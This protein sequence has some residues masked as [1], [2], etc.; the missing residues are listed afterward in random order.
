M[1]RE[2]GVFFIRRCSAQDGSARLPKCTDETTVGANV[3]AA[4]MGEVLRSTYSGVQ[5][6]SSERRWWNLPKRKPR[7]CL[8]SSFPDTMK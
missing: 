6:R 2:L 3:S 4:S 8:S 5:K 1:Q 7:V